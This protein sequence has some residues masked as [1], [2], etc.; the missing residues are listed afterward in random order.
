MSTG[1]LGDRIASTAGAAADE[2]LDVFLEHVDARGL[3]PYAAQEEALLELAAVS[4][5]VSLSNFSLAY[6]TTAFVLGPLAL[7]AY[8]EAAATAAALRRAAVS[9]AMLLGQP[10]F[11]ST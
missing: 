5:T 2:I 11:L 8:P 10:L 3:E 7:M 4:F 1:N 9:A 6:L